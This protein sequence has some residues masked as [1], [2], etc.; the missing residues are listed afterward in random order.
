M[1][2]EEFYLYLSTCHNQESH[3]LNIFNSENLDEIKES[4]KNVIRAMFKDYPLAWWYSEKYID[5]K[6]T[7]MVKPLSGCTTISKFKFP[8][9]H[10]GFILTNFPM[11][12]DNNGGYEKDFCI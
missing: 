11:F 6:A 7:E 5:D 9:F 12:P 4:I 3:A 1:E 2:K 8:F 10:L